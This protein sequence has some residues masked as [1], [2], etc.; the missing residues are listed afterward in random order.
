[1]TG[2]C[3]TAE[4]RAVFADIKTATTGIDSDTWI[5]SCIDKAYETLCRLK[6]TAL[7][8]VSP[9]AYAK[10]A[11]IWMAARERLQ[12]G[13]QKSIRLSGGFPMYVIDQKISEILEN[14]NGV[15]LTTPTTRSTIYQ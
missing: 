14:G 15:F 2:C 6:G 7:S 4:F 13:A 10:T 5:Q 9:P 1:M 3:S 11:N 8:T 12:R